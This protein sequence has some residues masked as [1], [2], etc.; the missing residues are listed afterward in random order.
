M[1]R[2]FRVYFNDSN[3]K[4]FKAPDIGAV[5]RHIADNLAGQYSPAD[6]TKIEEVQ[7]EEIEIPRYSAEIYCGRVR[8]GCGNFSTIE[9]CERFAHEDEFAERLVIYDTKTGEKQNM[10]WT[11]R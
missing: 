11:R 3:Q 10:R 7:E 4:L 6:I 2:T 1:A 8:V 5:C 9:E